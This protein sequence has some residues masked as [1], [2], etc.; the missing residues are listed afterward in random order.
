MPEVTLLGGDA[1]QDPYYEVLETLTD[2]LKFWKVTALASGD[3]YALRKEVVWPGS[4]GLTAAS[5]GIFADDAGMP[6][7]LLAQGAADIA[8]DRLNENYVNV[9][10]GTPVAVVVGTDYWIAIQVAG[11]MQHLVAVASGG[12]ETRE[13]SGSITDSPPTGL[14]SPEFTGPAFFFGGSAPDVVPV[15]SITGAAY[16]V[17]VTPL[18]IGVPETHEDA[19]GGVIPVALENTTL[20]TQ[21]SHLEV[22]PLEIGEQRAGSVT[23]SMHDPTPLAG[24]DVEGSLVASLKAF[25]QALWIGYKRPGDT[26]AEGLVYGQCNVRKSFADAT[27]TLTVQSAARMRAAQVR[28]GDI[29]L[30][31]DKNRGRL[32]AT[33]GLTEDPEGVE[34]YTIDAVIDAARNTLEQQERSVPALG[35]SFASLGEFPDAATAPFI[36]FERGQP[37]DDLVLQFARSITGS[38]LDWAPA[39]TWPATYYAQVQEWDPP[40]DPESPAATELGRN[41]D[42]ADPDDPQPGE[43]IFQIGM[44]DVAGKYVNNLVELDENPGEPRTHFHVLDEPKAFRETSADAAASE[45]V[46]VWTGWVEADITIPRASS[47]TVDGVRVI[48]PA[49]TAPLRA[50]ADAKVKAHAM[51]PAFFTCVLRPD[52]AQIYHFGHREWTGGSTTGDFYLGDY[53]RVRGREGQCEFSTLATIVAAKF[54]QDPS[55]GLPRLELTMIPAI[56]GT[57]G[58]DPTEA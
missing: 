31:I 8:T 28:R 27:I 41:L 46:G 32:R 6:G 34:R 22:D 51:P 37:V 58:D 50:L 4:T 19:E 13:S 11:T 30:N 43:V 54:T 42:P 44:P 57:P 18:L 12:T 55:N 9:V 23:I 3:V 25:Q 45:L 36:D 26:V 33:G 38:D 2:T 40:T 53:V 7:D 24:S 1:T 10:L 15:D 47:K 35:V 21:F 52:D 14:G 39:W 29:A 48:T 56:G 16:E 49:D 17:R 20:I 5:L